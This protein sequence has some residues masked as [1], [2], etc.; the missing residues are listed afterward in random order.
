MSK[1]LTIELSE[2]VYERLRRLAALRGLKIEDL[3]SRL[4]SSKSLDILA[5]IMSR[6]IDILS[7][8]KVP[9]DISPELHIYS[10]KQVKGRLNNI[11]KVYPIM[12]LE[13]VKISTVLLEN[14]DSVIVAHCGTVEISQEVSEELVDKVISISHIRLLRCSRNV[15]NTLFDR[16]EDVE[17]IETL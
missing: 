15:L 10:L 12:Y 5:I 11:F 1:V 13:E 14:V 9:Y 8:E 16:I 2:G 6:V 3:V 4:V 7:A 17:E